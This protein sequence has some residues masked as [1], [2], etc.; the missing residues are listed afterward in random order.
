MQPIQVTDRSFPTPDF[1]IIPV[2]MPLAICNGFGV[3]HTI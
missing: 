2:L 1:Y 3:I